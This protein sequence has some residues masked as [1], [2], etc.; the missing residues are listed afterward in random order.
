[1]FYEETRR[2][3][4][5]S[6][7]F[8]LSNN[9]RRTNCRRRKLRNAI[10]PVRW[11]EQNKIIG[12]CF[13]VVSYLKTTKKRRFRSSSSYA[14][15]CHQCPLDGSRV[16]QMN[17]LFFFLLDRP[18]DQSIALA[19]K[20]FFVVHLRTGNHQQVSFEHMFFNFIRK[21]ICTANAKISYT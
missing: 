21:T 11:E 8:C 18:R 6:F 1:M 17:C 19:P 10:L 7:V 3:T 20:V 4:K 13:V 2:K 12:L 15:K 14:E 5:R 16:S 9:T